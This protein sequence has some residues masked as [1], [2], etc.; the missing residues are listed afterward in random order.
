[1]SG[2]PGESVLQY[3]QTAMKLIV[4]T[5]VEGADM[6][7]RELGHEPAADKLL[8]LSLAPAVMAKLVTAELLL[9]KDTAWFW[10]RF[11]DKVVKPGL[12]MVFGPAAGST[13]I[14]VVAARPWH[15]LATGIAAVPP[16]SSGDPVLLVQIDYANRQLP[17]FWTKVSENFLARRLQDDARKQAQALAALASAA[18][19]AASAGAAA[20]KP[21]F[22]SWGT[23]SSS[24]R[25]AA[26][27]SGSSAVG[28]L[29]GDLEP[30]D[31]A[32]GAKE[33]AERGCKW[34]S[35]IEGSCRI[36]AACP[37][38]AFHK[39][40]VPSPWQ[41][42]KGKVYQAHGGVQ[43][44]KGDW[45]LPGASYAGVKRSSTEM[46]PTGPPSFPT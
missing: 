42:A 44:N 43:D 34:W 41:V 4:E 12:D 30:V 36:A 11:H 18:T 22:P 13:S 35:G 28:A 16:S 1:M 32:W 26:A 39:V 45:K 38:A 40:G 31:R 17:E 23:G 27:G 33:Q 10:D 3:T 6:A 5:F 14:D 7:C 24:T 25:F 8:S 29:R 9:Y 37:D 19:A 15:D 21:R 2:M 20:S 46:S